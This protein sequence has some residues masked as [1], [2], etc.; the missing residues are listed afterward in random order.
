MSHSDRDL[1][2]IFSEG[3][4]KCKNKYENKT[5]IPYEREA[6]I[7]SGNFI[8][9]ED[10]IQGN[11]LTCPRLYDGW[12]CWPPTKAGD[13]PIVVYQNC[14]P[15]FEYDVR[16]YA[17]KTCFPNG[18]WFRHPG[19]IRDDDTWT[20]YTRCADKEDLEFRQLIND[21][22]VKGYIISLITLIFSLTIF[23]SF[24]SLKC[25][26]IRI[27]IHLFTSLAMTCLLWILW[28]KLVVER[29]NILEE[30]PVWCVILHLA[31]QYLM[32][33]NYFWMFCEGLHL[34][35]VLVVVFVKDTI[36]MR[37]FMAIGWLA[38]ILFITPYGAIRG[39]YSENTL[40]CWMYNSDLL[41]ILTVPVCLTLFI[42]FVFLINVVRVLVKKLHPCSAQPAPL[43]IRK[44]VRATIIL[45][46]LFGI[47]HF[48]IPYRPEHGTPLEKA[49]ELMSVFLVSLQGVCVSCL[50]CFANHDVLFVMRNLLS[51]VFPGII[52]PP[53]PSTNT[54]QIATQTPS[55]ELGV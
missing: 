20:N 6:Y 37:W 3:Y 7:D 53:P 44:A 15:K 50:F 17:H 31:Q 39:Y 49:Y 34:H 51:R 18:T 38:P 33:V 27:H 25:T 48:L 23:L 5:F 36:V 40:F 1:Y 13:L 26:R 22:Y 41:W 28:Y 19:R 47:Q 29:I 42:S 32:L 35:L 54:G 52:Q 55:R 9:V 43:A 24:R 16:R 8:T 14:P 46:P 10:E 2:N 45:V 30:N 11:N 21:L 12:L 4:Y